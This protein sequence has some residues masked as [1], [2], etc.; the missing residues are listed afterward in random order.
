MNWERSKFYLQ[1]KKYD[2]TK[3]DQTCE[4]ISFEKTSA[5]RHGNSS[6]YFILGLN[7]WLEPASA[8]SEA[9]TSPQSP[10]D[11]SEKG[12]S[13]ETCYQRVILSNGW[14]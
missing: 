8:G 13:P 10:K 14:L 5:Y 3:I 4:H 11:G 6:Y 9:N 7:P 12:F 2:R 1:S